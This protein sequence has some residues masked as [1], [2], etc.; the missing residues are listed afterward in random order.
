MSTLRSLAKGD[1]PV[2]VIR[3]RLVLLFFIGLAAVLLWRAIDLQ[4][5]RH[6]P[7][8]L[9]QGEMRHL[10]AVKMPAHRGAITDRH[11]QPLAISTPVESVWVNPQKLDPDR[12]L[13]RQL[14]SVLDVDPTR[15]AHMLATREQRQFLYLRRHVPPD[16]AE[17]VRQLKV[18][19]VYLQRE[20]RRY[21][22]ARDVA[23]H[24]VGFTDI[25]DRGLEGLELAYNDWLTGKDGAK[26]AIQDRL[27]RVVEDVEHIA[28]VE[29]GRQLRLSIDLRLQTL[30][31]RALE[32]GV[33]RH[34]AKGG[35]VV[36][37]D[38]LT[39]EV[40]AMSNQPAYNPNAPRERR[41]A[42]TR[43]RAVTDVYEP[44]STFKP[45]T[46]AAAMEVSELQPDSPID[47]GRGLL[48]VGKHTV[49]D[50][51]PHGLIDVRRV[52]EL[53]SNVGASQIAL[54]LEREAFWD[55]LAGIGIGVQTGVGFPGESAGLL[56]GIEEW[57]DIHVATL[58]FGY[59]VAVT[60]L[61]LA[62]AYSVIANNGRMIAPTLLARVEPPESTRVFRS[63]VAVQVRAM[64]QS[65]VTDGT[66]KRAQV[67][68][69]RVAGK[70]GT[71]RKSERGGYA[72]NRYNSLFAGIAPASRPR[73]V[74]VVLVDEP[75]GTNYQGGRV[76][77]PI[78]SEIMA[79]ALRL[80]RVAP[81][82]AS[83]LPHRI[84]LADADEEALADVLQAARP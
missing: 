14:A 80:L 52:L 3:Q 20:Y 27:G 13:W 84:A 77:A 61:Q 81:D 59:G 33:K 25:D 15:L 24:I 60:P 68:G 16:V 63:D 2:G 83:E 7:F 5:Y 41:G 12:Q 9:E 57:R 38:T 69:Y 46:V 30:A 70:T 67:A 45:L 39:G 44:G 79:G 40:L 8:L 71:A 28:K 56:V 62:Q 47:T 4:T 66:G 73:L 49:R 50:D 36:L 82:N 74:L 32:A 34:G 78:F 26:Y 43:N 53:S 19:G 48:R 42:R 54:G 17:R 72:K 22:P 35:S 55:G 11:G 31:H 23:G 29:N 6:R 51:P 64:L 65:V 58:A 10:R 75:Q 18:A 37:L 21:Y 1:S 76:A